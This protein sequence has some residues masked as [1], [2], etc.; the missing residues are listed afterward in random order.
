MIA[1]TEARP[2]Q[3]GPWTP[4]RL[5]KIPEYKRQILDALESGLWV[6]EIAQQLQV[7]VGAIQAWRQ[8]DVDFGARYREAEEKFIDSLERVA[9]QRATQGVADV[10]ISGGKIVMDPRSKPEDPQ[11]LLRRTYSDGLLMFVLK[12]RRREVYGDKL[13]TDN[14][15]QINV[16]GAKDSLAAK[17]RAASQ[18]AHRTS[19]ATNAPPVAPQLSDGPESGAAGAVPGEPDA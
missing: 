19:Q 11:P 13:E 16:D 5:R 8:Q 1:E 12:G 3:Y 7:G 6:A 10:V 4:D 2:D 14:K 18:A 15:H 17:L 9:I